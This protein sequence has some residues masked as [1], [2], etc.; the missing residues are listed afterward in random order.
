MCDL[1]LMPVIVFCN[2]I[3]CHKNYNHTLFASN[4]EILIV[5]MAL[6]GAKKQGT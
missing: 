3:Y 1:Q 2:A 5:Y 6:A 4:T